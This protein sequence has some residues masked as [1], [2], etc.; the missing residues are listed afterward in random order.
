M[1]ALFEVNT[2]PNFLFDKRPL[3]LIYEKLKS[4]NRKKPLNNNK[5]IKEYINNKEDNH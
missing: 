2:K 3:I 1:L 4:E 5:L